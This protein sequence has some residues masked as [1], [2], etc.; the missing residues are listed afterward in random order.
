M[1]ALLSVKNL[2]SDTIISIKD[3]RFYLVIRA[4]NEKE[5]TDSCKVV[6]M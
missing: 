3:N 4:T 2:P 1:S 5:E 6:S